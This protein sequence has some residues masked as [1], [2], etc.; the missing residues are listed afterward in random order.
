[1]KLFSNVKMHVVV[2]KNIRI[3]FLAGGEELIKSRARLP[4]LPALSIS[5]SRAFTL[6]P[7]MSL[8]TSFSSYLLLCHSLFTMVFFFL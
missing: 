6:F 2:K 3:K 8:S 1:M 7:L 5:S 4:N